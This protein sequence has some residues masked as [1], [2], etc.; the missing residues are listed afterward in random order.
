MFLNENCKFW[1]EYLYLGPSG[2]AT[3][4]III[5]DRNQHKKSNYSEQHSPQLD[6]FW[7]DRSD[8]NNRLGEKSPL[9]LKI[10]TVKVN[11]IPTKFNQLTKES[12]VVL[13]MKR[14][15]WW[16]FL[17][18]WSN[19]NRKKFTCLCVIFFYLLFAMAKHHKAYESEK[20]PSK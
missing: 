19:S 5:S 12:Q 3:D 9:I 17:Y 6:C 1:C 4:H 11:I 10:E 13:C 2:A 18:I 7:F 14:N 8:W 15:Q 16:C 20:T